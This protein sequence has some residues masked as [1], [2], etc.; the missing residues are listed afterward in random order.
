[1]DTPLSKAKVAA[2]PIAHTRSLYQVPQAPTTI[3]AASQ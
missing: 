2:I 3:L 1:M